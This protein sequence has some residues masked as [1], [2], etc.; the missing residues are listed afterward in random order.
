[1]RSAAMLA[2]KSGWPVA[3]AASCLTSSSAISLTTNLVFAAGL[4]C[5]F[6][7]GVALNDWPLMGAN[8]VSMV[9][10]LVIITMK[11]RYG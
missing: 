5:W 6:I 3:K 4:V 7:Y 9:F 1:M 11:L 2:A 8:A 10:T